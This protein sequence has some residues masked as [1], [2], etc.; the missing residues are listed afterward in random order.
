LHSSRSSTCR[1]PS[2]EYSETIQQ[3]EFRLEK[4]TQE[5]RELVM[6]TSLVFSEKQELERSKLHQE[7][8]IR[9][10]EHAI[11]RLQLQVER[12]NRHLEKH[13]L[14]PLPA[15]SGAASNKENVINTSR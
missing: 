14:P 11:T 2:S 10:L 15:A 4:L 9:D 13:G 1:W 6:K 12:A 3:Y 7:A 5:K 8:R